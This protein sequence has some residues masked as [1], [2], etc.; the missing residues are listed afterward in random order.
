ME[1]SRARRRTVSSENVCPVGF[2]YF[3]THQIPLMDGSPATSRSTSSMSGPLSSM[4]TF[5]I[6]KPSDSVIVKCRS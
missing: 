5:S 2:W 6:S 4:R 3:G 1:P